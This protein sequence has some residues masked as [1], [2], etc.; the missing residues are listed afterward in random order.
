MVMAT[1][2]AMTT[3]LVTILLLI[4]TVITVTTLRGVKE[5]G[6]DEPVSYKL[7]GQLLWS[8]TSK[9]PLPVAQF[10]HLTAQARL[11]LRHRP[12]DETK[13]DG[14]P[15]TTAGSQPSDNPSGSSSNKME[16]DPH[17]PPGKTYSVA[18]IEARLLRP[19]TT[20]LTFPRSDSSVSKIQARKLATVQCL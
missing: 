1:T 20:P 18:A 16:G 7:R 8:T 2:M 17:S 19:R 10:L 11:F 5:L 13:Q 6:M 14:P 12:Q 3:T 4:V 15:Q 9:L